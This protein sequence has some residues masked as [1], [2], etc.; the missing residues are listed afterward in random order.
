MKVEIHNL[1]VSNSVISLDVTLGSGEAQSSCK[2]SLL[3][4]DGQIRDTLTKRTV[5]TKGIVGVPK[6]KQ[7]IIIPTTSP[8]TTASA[9]SGPISSTVTGYS[10]GSG[11]I[12]SYPQP[13]DVKARITGIIKECLRQGV[14]DV[15]QIAYI[16]ATVK[17]ECGPGGYAGALPGGY[18]PVK[19]V[20]SNFRYD[21]WRG[22]GLIQV[23]WK[24]NY[25]K[26]KAASGR[27]VIADPDLLIKDF[28]LSCWAIVWGMKGGI[29]TGKKLSDY[30]NGSSRDFIGARR[31]VNG[32]D[33]ASL[34]DGYARQWLIDLPPYISAAQGSVAA[35]AT[36]TTTTTTATTATTA[37]TTP[38][39]ATTAVSEPLPE[40]DKIMIEYEGTNF[41]FVYGGFTGTQESATVE[42]VG[43]GARKGADNGVTLPQTISNASVSDI[44][45]GVANATGKTVKL[46]GSTPT[47]KEEVVVGSLTPTQL[48]AK[49]ADSVGKT[50]T[51]NGSSIILKDKPKPGG[52]PTHELVFSIGVS[53]SDKPVSDLSVVTGNTVKAFPTVVTIPLNL[54]IEAGDGIKSASLYPPGRDWVVD[55][56]THSIVTGR[57]SINIYSEMEANPTLINIPQ[58]VQAPISGAVVSAGTIAPNVNATVAVNSA[59]GYLAKMLASALAN[60]GA[61]SASGPGGG[62]VACAWAVNRWVLLPVLGRNYGG[63]AKDLVTE[64]IADMKREGWAD[65][66]AGQAPPGAICAAW[67]GSGGHI[68]I[69]I[70]S[71]ADPIALSNSSSRASWSGEYPWVAQMSS[72]Y[73]GCE[74][75]FMVINK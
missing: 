49:E 38:T 6:P 7:A 3:D 71:G 57:T 24:N 31:I 13:Q 48:L 28:G 37:A 67:N 12:P 29:Y 64:V 32:T 8:G 16:L 33:K 52:T 72:T 22:R 54:E 63:A 53:A 56:V 19:E 75:H 35:V 30:I 61:S 20:G 5:E 45:T 60:R 50:V 70:R 55:A 59:S 69:I 10:L 23:T 2:M 34:F 62:R 25:E 18:S 39:T 68:G 65:V 40:A 9:T 74:F 11:G 43:I 66:P 36:S 21:P 41:E 14:T 58:P 47:K 4:I 46:T 42:V 73:R 26:V 44:A 15:G 17:G 27:D 1:D 51:D